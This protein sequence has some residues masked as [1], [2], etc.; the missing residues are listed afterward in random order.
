MIP[1]HLFSRSILKLPKPSFLV[2][3]IK[4][5]R[6]LSIQPNSRMSHVNAPTNKI[7]A[8]KK[9]SICTKNWFCTIA[10][11]IEHEFTWI[12]EDFNLQIAN[13]RT[14]ELK[15]LTLSDHN[16]SFEW[17]LEPTIRRIHKDNDLKLWCEWLDFNL[18]M[19]CSSARF[20]PISGSVSV[21]LMNLKNEKS[22]SYTQDFHLSAEHEF[23]SGVG[24]KLM[25]CSDLKSYLLPEGELKIH[26]K[27]AFIRDTITASNHFPLDESNLT[28]DFE[29]L[30]NDED[31]SDIIIDV[32]GKKFPAHKSILA[33]N[34]PVFQAMF[35]NDLMKNQQSRIEINDIDEKIFQEVLRCIYT[36][37]VENLNDIVFELIPVAVKYDIEPLKRACS[38]KFSELLSEKTAVKMLIFAHLNSVSN[39]KKKANDY[40][41]RN[42]KK[43]KKSKDWNDLNAYPDLKKTIQQYT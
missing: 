41:R 38:K 14:E 12:I 35:K 5:I 18:K 31:S 28:H 4:E 9:D 24:L 1:M 22:Y 26:F 21:S 7:P 2:S 10:K 34:S 25:K 32:N 30:F 16:D 29:K 20:S 37:K 11:K 27:I 43:V 42:I 13:M 17:V 8:L 15:C 39:L 33:V 3:S 36:R 40:I 19:S 23:T 6:Y